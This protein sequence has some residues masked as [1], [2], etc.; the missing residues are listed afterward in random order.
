MT[1]LETL[2]TKFVLC[3]PLG[4]L[5]DMLCQIEICIRY[6]E[7]THRSV[8]VDPGENQL[9]RQIFSRLIVHSSHVNVKICGTDSDLKFLE[10]LSTFPRELT[11]RITSYEPVT[12]EQQ[13]PNA[14]FDNRT[15][16]ELAFD[17]D[18][19]YK[20]EV[21]IHHRSGGG[22]QSK[23]MLPRIEITPSA[24]EEI[25][26]LLSKIP[27]NYEALHVRS[28]DY[29]TNVNRFLKLLAPRIEGKKVLVCSDNPE[30]IRSAKT[31]IQ[32]AEFFS[33]Q[34]PNFGK[35][36]AVTH[37]PENN[38]LERVAECNAIL[39]LAEL[40]A[41][42]RADHLF[43]TFIE[44][45]PFYRTVR[46]SGFSFLLGQCISQADSVR[47]FEWLGLRDSLIPRGERFV[48][49]APWRIKLLQELQSHRHS[50]SK[51]LRKQ[52]NAK[53]SFKSRSTI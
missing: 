18:S 46:L 16:V 9:A 28:S 50:L 20:E 10:G 8:I 30:V 32:G 43:T 49:L 6:A 37:A 2:G 51:R 38:V 27:K 1:P 23:T 13:D 5:N 45:K 33:L 7:K 3:R 31:R 17:L 12:I 22:N 19:D 15:G 41:V 53:T 29:E 4:G 36:G 26:E 11:G 40:V 48:V 24:R 52:L 21:L 25:Q 34:P 35:T 44:R 39:I 14:R 47:L 42:S